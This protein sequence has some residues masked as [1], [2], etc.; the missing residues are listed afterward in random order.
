MS[1]YQLQKLIYHVNRDAER[2]GALLARDHLV[3]RE[4][5]LVVVLGDEAVG[6]RHRDPD[7]GQAREHRRGGRRHQQPGPGF[8]V[9]GGHG[10]TS[11]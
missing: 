2:R 5:L 9:P 6:A 8:A 7:R 10:F 3:E 11:R 1:L 4:A